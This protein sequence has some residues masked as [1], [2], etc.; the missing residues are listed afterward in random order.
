MTEE[1]AYSLIYL[2]LNLGLILAPTIGGMLFENYLNLAFVIDGLTTLSSTILIFLFIK[3]ITPVENQKASVYEEAKGQ[4]STWSV[5]W[6][7]KIILWFFA[8]WAIYNFVYAQFNFLIPL[9]LEGLYQAKGAVYFGFL[10]SLNGLIVI[11]GTPLLTKYTKKLPDT[12]KLIAGAGLV[13]FGLSMYIF[14]QGI[15]P[16]YYVSMIIFT[17]GEIMSTLGTYPYMT[18]RVPASHRGR[19]SSV[20]NIFLGIASYYSQ[21]C[22]GSL[23]E[24]ESMVRVWTIIAGIGLAGIF[25][26][27]ILREADKK[28]FP[29]LYKKL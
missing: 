16:M 18:R 28:R 14:I 4:V 12:S 22:I 24:K 1:R 7:K 25:L 10:T 20:A 29:L 6:E 8:A 5:L 2:G 26:Y 27:F 17:L 15:I 3:D 19:I 11:I 13:T 21:W 23:L 9:N